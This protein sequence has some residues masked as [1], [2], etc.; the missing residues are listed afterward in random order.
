MPFCFEYQERICARGRGE[1]FLQIM[2]LIQA[3]TFARDILPKEKL[4][5]KIDDFIMELEMVKAKYK[6]VVH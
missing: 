3:Y 5:S 4:I 6:G 2:R 1:S